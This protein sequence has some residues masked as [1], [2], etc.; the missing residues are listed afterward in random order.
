MANAMYS[1]TT[2]SSSGAAGV[3]PVNQ[4]QQNGRIS[5]VFPEEGKIRELAEQIR[6]RFVRAHQLKVAIQQQQQATAAINMQVSPCT[7]IN[8]TRHAY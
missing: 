5:G 6:T 1:S 2:S 7:H 3:G 4:E 8:T